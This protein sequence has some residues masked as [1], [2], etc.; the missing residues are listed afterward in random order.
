MYKEWPRQGRIER[1]HFYFYLNSRRLL[2]YGTNRKLHKS[3]YYLEQ[4]FL[5][6][7][8]RQ[9]PNC[10]EKDNAA[11]TRYPLADFPL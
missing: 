1:E 9:P 11:L 4:R 2:I 5:I 10:V 3:F 8:G 7:N 6:I